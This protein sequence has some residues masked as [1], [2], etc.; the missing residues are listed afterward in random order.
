[1]KMAHTDTFLIYKDQ[2]WVAEVGRKY[3]KAF[4]FLLQILFKF[5]A[6]SY[7][8]A[9]AS[10]KETRFNVAEPAVKITAGFWTY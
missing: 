6:Y 10:L 5:W 2:K 7:K 9:R 8:R 1:M 3:E 4:L